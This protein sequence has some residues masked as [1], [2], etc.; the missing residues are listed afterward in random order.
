[1]SEQAIFYDDI[2]MIAA[3]L[4]A[5]LAHMGLSQ[6]DLARKMGR[7]TGYVSEVARGLKRP[8]TDLLLA[9]KRE[10][11]VSIDWLLTGAGAMFGG[12]GIRH[13]LLRAILIQIAVADLGEG[14][15]GHLLK[16]ADGRIALTWG[17][18]AAPFAMRAKISSDQ[19]YT[20]GPEIDLKT[21][22]G[23]R[24]IAV[25]TSPQN[26]AKIVAYDLGGGGDIAVT[27]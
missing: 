24:D 3:R 16:L 2:L 14:N 4:R 5:V 21:N 9:L 22:G 12:V 11:E 23:G 10:F 25:P 15:P 19:G 18:R 17:F 7:S 13:D 6:T 26:I 20:W 8:G 27:T 1:M